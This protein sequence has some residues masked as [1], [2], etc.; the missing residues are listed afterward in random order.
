MMPTSNYEIRRG[1]LLNYFDETAA[2]KWEALTSDDPVSGIRATVRAGRDKMRSILLDRLPADLTGKRVLD[3]GC[4][5]GALADQLA[6]RGAC[7]VAV[8]LSPRMIE[9][10]NKRYV[11]CACDGSVDF[12]AGDMLDES[13]GDFDHIV[14]MD[15]FIHYEVGDLVRILERLVARTRVS[16]NFTIAPRT[17]ALAMMHKVGRWFPQ[18]D[19]APSIQPIVPSRLVT[20][21]N[22]LESIQD[23]HCEETERVKSGFYISEAI[24]MRKGTLTKGDA[25]E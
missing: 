3:A 21:L 16:L 12:R 6:K 22:T 17:P 7:V 8:D 15:S 20:L 25:T 9:I 13:L 14:A 2:D 18:N 24:S 11:D 19:R 4:G 23:W 1:E 5:T 10:A